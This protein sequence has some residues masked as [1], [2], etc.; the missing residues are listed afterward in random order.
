MVLYTKMLKLNLFSDEILSTPH[1][2][3]SSLVKT[4]NVA[5]FFNY[6]LVLSY[7]DAVAVL[8]SSAVKG[9]NSITPKCPHTSNLIENF[10]MGFS[11]RLQ[12]VAV[13]KKQIDFIYNK[14]N[15]TSYS[16]LFDKTLKRFNSDSAIDI[17]DFSKMYSFY[18]STNIIDF[19]LSDSF[20]KMYDN[21]TNKVFST[22]A[23]NEYSHP[24]NEKT[25]ELIKKYRS[26]KGYNRLKDEY[27]KDLDVDI[28]SI[29]SFLVFG[30]YVSS[31]STLALTIR[32]LQKQPTLVNFIKN[33][34]DEDILT[35]ISNEI[36]RLASVVKFVQRKV[37]SEFSSPNIRFKAGD[38]LLICL[39]SANRD[40]RA[41]PN[42]E[43]IYKKK[44]ENQHLAFAL[45][46]YYCAGAGLAVKNF[47]TI[48]PKLA[49]NISAF[50][51]ENISYKR[52]LSLI[53]T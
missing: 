41:F 43:N 9:F 5:S 7:E 33:C 12:H 31:K 29:F 10:P 53:L 26:A 47:A 34:N 48:L 37:I 49:H 21:V 18:A 46:Q 25:L 45:G 52:N 32:L 17:L 50:K 20:I 6:K 44:R 22:I 38:V 16:Q 19:N 51:N 42:P 2:F 28:D 35:N 39:I 27:L 24:I 4:N 23:T 30:S 11:N 1:T 15:T 40:P 3:F 36:I 14:K 8:K 13:K